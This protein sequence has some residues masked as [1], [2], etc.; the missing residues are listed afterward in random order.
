MVTSTNHLLKVSS[1]KLVLCFEVGSLCGK[2][3]AAL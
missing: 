2:G 3:A 1:H